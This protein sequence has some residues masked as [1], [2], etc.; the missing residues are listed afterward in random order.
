MSSLSFDER[1][2]MFGGGGGAKANNNNNQPKQAPGK[3][4]VPTAFST[5]NQGEVPKKQ[6]QKSLK[7]VP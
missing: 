6:T 2:K 1:V 7:E 5:G 3:I 4:K